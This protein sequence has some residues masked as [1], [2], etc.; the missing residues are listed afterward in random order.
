MI[1]FVYI[2]SLVKM[3][4][5]IL[6]EVVE[7][8]PFNSWDTECT[9]YNVFYLHCTSIHLTRPCLI[10]SALDIMMKIVAYIFAI[11]SI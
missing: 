8:N 3:I 2:E 10:F 9:M 6:M 1:L 5:N 11:L 7:K 4:D